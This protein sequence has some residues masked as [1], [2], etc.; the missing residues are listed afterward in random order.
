VDKVLLQLRSL[1]DQLEP[2]LLAWEQAKTEDKRR[3]AHVLA[4][5]AA[6]ELQTILN[7]LRPPAASWRQ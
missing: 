5:A 2:P 7:A 6:R 4:T 3:D 1:I